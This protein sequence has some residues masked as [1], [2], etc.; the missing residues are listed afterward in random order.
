MKSPAFAYQDIKI[1]A[2]DGAMKVKCK[3]AEQ[4]ESI[5]PS[6]RKQNFSCAGRN[7]AP[8]CKNSTGHL[9]FHKNK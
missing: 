5:S 4:L 8:G 2:N 6:I 3:S 9:Y 7:G 1:K